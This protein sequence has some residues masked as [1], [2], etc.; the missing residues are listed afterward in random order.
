MSRRRPRHVPWGNMSS[1]VDA[2]SREPWQIL[3]DMHLRSA[4]YAPPA[5]RPIPAPPVHLGITPTWGANIVAYDPAHGPCPACGDARLRPHEVCLVC[6]ASATDAVRWPMQ[7]PPLDSRVRRR[8]R[9][10]LSET[11][12]KIHK[13]TQVSDA[14]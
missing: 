14:A 5:R 6:H 13:I 3:A 9:C 4:N 11:D 1:L 10:T 12:T 7:G 2:R 8:R